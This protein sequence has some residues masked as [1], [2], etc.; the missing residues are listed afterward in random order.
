MAKPQAVLDYEKKNSGKKKVKVRD[1]Q[2]ELCPHPLKG[3][4]SI[5]IHFKQIRFYKSSFF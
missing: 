3:V 2:T 5:I 4:F 1:G